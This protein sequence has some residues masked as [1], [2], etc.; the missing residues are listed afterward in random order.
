MEETHEIFCSLHSLSNRFCLVLSHISSSIPLSPLPYSIS[1]SRF[2]KISYQFIIFFENK[3]FR[4]E[5]LL[6]STFESS[7]FLL[8][9]LIPQCALAP[10]IKRTSLHLDLSQWWS[11]NAERYNLI[12]LLIEILDFE[13][14]K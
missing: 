7:R 3:L 4:R 1:Q 12:H 9:D 14:I 2:S 11:A 6:T 13:L 10:F 5:S 8:H